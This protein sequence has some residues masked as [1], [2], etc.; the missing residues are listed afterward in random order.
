MPNYL[1]AGYS[2][3]SLTLSNEFIRVDLHKRLTG[4]GWA[5]LFTHEGKYLGVLDHFGEVMLRD[6]E[7][8]M[9]ME[10]DTF[11]RRDDADGV[12]LVFPVKSM[13]VQQKLKGTSFD[14]WI[15]YPFKEHLL[16]GEVVLTLPANESCLKLQY[17][18]KSKF[19]LFV[20][21]VRGPW[22]KIGADGFGSNKTDAIFPGIE[23]LEKEEWS[24]GT[25]WFKDP[26]AL[27]YAPH[28]NKVAIPAMVVSH[29]GTAVGLSWNP[30]Q[31][32]TQWFNYRSHRPQPVFASPN[33]IDRRNNHLMG[34][35]VPD[36]ESDDHENAI[37][38]DPPLELHPDQPIEWDA[39]IFVVEGNSL[40]GI[41]D[42]IKRKGMPESPAPRW[43]YAEA[44][45]RI[46]NA[47]STRF[48]RE[49]EGFGSPQHPDSYAPRLPRFLEDYL[50][51]A[52][53]DSDLWRE[54]N[55]KRDWCMAASRELA[56]ESAGRQETAGSVDAVNAVI[57]KLTERGLKLLTYQL[58]RG[59]FPFDPE[60]R[61]YRKDDFVVARE[62]VEPMGLAGDTALDMSM[63]PTLELI[64]LWEETSD[65]RFREGAVRALDYCM[66]MTRPE[67][68]DFWETPLHSPNLL[69]GGHAAI[70]YYKAYRAFGDER[71]LSKAV[72][73]IRSILPFT[74]LW[75]PD[76]TPMLYNT[77]PCFC[78]SDWYFANWVRDH[79]QWE[80]LGIF[81]DSWSQGID[82]AEIDKDVDWRRYQEGIT[83]AALRWMID[84]K[85]ENW[86]P[87]NLP[88]TRD[89]YRQGLLDDCF[90]D[91]HNSVTGNY[92]GMAILPD[93]IAVNLIALLARNS[94]LT[95]H[96]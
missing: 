90:A 41:T 34:L 80:V 23:W 39:E 72:Y 12:T 57:A 13:I 94:P 82:W 77:K 14:S 64:S 46:A 36:I 1:Q 17:R 70:A 68:G 4:W 71:Y 42:W 40:D 20:R 47:Y 79:V 88:A 55:R 92:G 78:S 22:L 73:W 19:N 93:T 16:E 8:P 7:I 24:S 18:L 67:G 37:L 75:Q 5:E 53:Q 85:L 91:T 61:H 65:E 29:E 74:H 15:Q 76:N 3:E 25:D 27:R 48:W 10:A 86:Q 87:H 44:L 49:G 28:P 58:A 26:W 6:Q 35:M 89:I 32:A 2:G 38:A 66:G 84:H 83:N 62:F 50:R 81:A 31:R 63:L 52:E 45:D 30:R 60:G 21:Y 96:S 95:I 69:A 11:E 59:A 33:F 9:R 51:M 43:P 56:A 54:L